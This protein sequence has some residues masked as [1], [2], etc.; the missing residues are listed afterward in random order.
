MPRPKK[1]RDTSGEIKC[2]LFKPRG[3][4][5]RYLTEIIL[6][7]D[8]FEAIRLADF[9]SLSHQDAADKMNISRPT[10]S[11]LVE[12]GRHKVSDALVNGFAL[13]ISDSTESSAELPLCTCSLCGCKKKY[14]INKETGLCF[15]CI[16]KSERTIIMKIAVA[17]N[18]NSTITGHI[19]KC[20]GFIMYNIEENKVSS[21]E[22][23][24]NTFTHHAQNQGEHNHEEH[25]H[26]GEGY[27]HGHGALLSALSGVS[28]MIFAG[29]G[30]R[31]I[32]DLKANGITPV[33]TQHKDA[34]S[35]VQLL[36]EGELESQ[37]D[38]TCHSH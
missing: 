31:L 34:D 21:R 33:L 8:E 3:I 14:K 2:R 1:L 11:R 17:S 5:A 20:K 25:Q 10:F 13:K 16:K 28:H 24:T 35:A 22:Y 9:E 30:W 23:L 7:M 19:G 29:G 15:D 38:L 27:G 36:L 37:D 18:D 26:Q 4:P 32:E 6:E 12:K